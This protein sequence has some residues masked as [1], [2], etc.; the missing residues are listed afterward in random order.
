MAAMPPN[1]TRTARKA[2]KL[3]PMRPPERSDTGAGAGN[4]CLTR[5][6]VSILQDETVNN[7]SIFHPE[8]RS[9][10]NLPF[11]RIFLYRELVTGDGIEEQD[12]ALTVGHLFHEDRVEAR[13]GAFPDLY[14]LARGQG[15]PFRLQLDDPL[16]VHPRADG[17]DDLL[18]HF[19]GFQA[20]TD[21]AGDAVGI[22]DR[23][24][25]VAVEP[26]EE[27]GRKEGARL[28][29]APVTLRF[30]ADFREENFVAGTGQ[31]LVDPCFIERFRLYQEPLRIQA[32]PSRG[33]RHLGHPHAL[34]MHVSCGMGRTPDYPQTIPNPV[35][36]GKREGQAELAMTRRSGCGHYAAE[37]G[38][39]SNFAGPSNCGTWSKPARE[40]AIPVEEP[41]ARQVRARSPLARARQR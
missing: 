26:D 36:F 15:D 10:G 29:E 14:A 16:L 38:S 30:P 37:N 31:A 18:I 33:H 6:T 19:V 8:A 40:R 13:K 5:N 7:I 1:R 28:E 2:S 34:G 25:L 24:Q 4:P 23:L 35:N 39:A 11:Q 20:E 17:G 32:Q 21:D 27:V 12:H 3:P 22:F 41:R 9:G